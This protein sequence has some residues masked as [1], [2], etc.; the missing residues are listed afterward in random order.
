MEEH[1]HEGEARKARQHGVGALPLARSE[2]R[3]DLPPEIVTEVAKPIPPRRRVEARNAE[4]ASPL[5][6]EA[7]KRRQEPS[8]IVA[9]ALAEAC[10]R[11]RPGELAVTDADDTVARYEL[12]A[13]D[14]DRQRRGELGQECDL[15]RDPRLDFRPAREAEDPLPVDLEDEAVPAVLD[16]VYIAELELGEVRPKCVGRLH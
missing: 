12:E 1:G 9:R 2:Q 8:E 3:E 15:A 16:D 7:V 14:C 4:G 11:R 6:R 10:G 13:W 5:D